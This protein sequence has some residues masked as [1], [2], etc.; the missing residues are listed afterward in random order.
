MS[1][2]VRRLRKDPS[3]VLCLTDA[4]DVI[5]AACPHLSPEGC[6]RE[7]G[8]AIRVAERDLAVLRVLATEV[9]AET[10]VATAYG[11]LRKHITPQLMADSLCKRCSWQSHGYCTEGLL[12]LKDFKGAGLPPS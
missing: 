8:A 12:R 6:R 1:Y 2:V 7:P 9:G 5:C 10:T 3:A 11:L 4:A